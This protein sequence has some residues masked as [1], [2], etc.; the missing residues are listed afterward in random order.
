MATVA[1]LSAL[2]YISERL[3]QDLRYTSDKH[4]CIQRGYSLPPP[5]C[6][7]E[8]KGTLKERQRRGKGAPLPH[9]KPLRYLDNLTEVYAS[10]NVCSSVS[11]AVFVISFTHVHWLINLCP[12]S[13]VSKQLSMSNNFLRIFKR[14]SLN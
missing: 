12:I 10:G 11:K 5:S 14:K 8:T 9:N 6:H 7:R 2:H 13:G 4:L 3:T 1:S